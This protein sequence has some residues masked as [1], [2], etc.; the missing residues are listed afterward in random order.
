MMLKPGLTGTLI[1][2]LVA[3]VVGRALALGAED[4]KSGGPEAKAVSPVIVTAMPSRHSFTQAIP[5]IG[6]VESQLSVDLVTHVDGRV[7]EIDASDQRSVR[8]G[9]VILR[10]GGPQIETVRARL[11]GQ[12]SSLQALLD[13][14]QQTLSRLQQ[15]LQEQLAT[16]DQIATVQEERVKLETQLLQAR[17]E[18]ENLRRQALIQAN[19]SGIFTNR[20]V[21]VGADV[22]AGQT[23]GSIIDPRRL[24]IVAALFPPSG[25]SLEGKDAAIRF[26][27]DQTVHGRVSAV[28]PEASEAGA[29]GVWIE[30]P[31]I[32]QRLRPGQTV[33]GEVIAATREALA[34][35]ETALVYDD[36]ERPYLFL[37]NK[38]GYASQSVE[39]GLSQ[40]GWVEIRSGLNPDQPVV[41][42]GA[43]EL[44][45]RQ[46]SQQF[47]VPD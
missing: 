1:L 5:W 17:L 40:D 23:L 45:Y 31:D 12:V 15:G 44:F 13:L 9:Q 36:Q 8:T 18:L 27:A 22:R 35:P 24:R 6:K 32:A 21:S 39:T 43:Y 19:S 29:T 42:Q 33:Q 46:F 2:S 4:S 41:V 25:L 34:V 14:N 38:D 10:L 28:L 7:L 11:S 20:K 16:K 26:D 3:L 47:K 37:Q 30:S